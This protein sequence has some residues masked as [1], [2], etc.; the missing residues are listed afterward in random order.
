MQIQDLHL[1]IYIPTYH[2]I[3]RKCFNVTNNMKIATFTDEGC[4]LTPLYWPLIAI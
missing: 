4:H 3:I 1:H 2:L